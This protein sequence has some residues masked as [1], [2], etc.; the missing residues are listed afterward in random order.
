MENERDGTVA[1]MTGEFLPPGVFAHDFTRNFVETWI[2]AATAQSD[3]FPDFRSRLSAREC[4]WF[5]RIFE[6]SAG[7]RSLGSGET[8][9]HNLENFIRDLWIDFLRRRRGELPVADQS[10]E[11]QR[12]EISYNMRRFKDV[13]WNGV[14]TLIRE[15]KKGMQ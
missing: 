6:E 15:L 3:P 13:K 7:G 4:R 2:A 1:A 5:D 9:A 11:A 8:V 12:F 10:V 14:K